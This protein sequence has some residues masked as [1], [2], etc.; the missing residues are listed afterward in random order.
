MQN[1]GIDYSLGQSNTDSETGIRYGVINQNAVG[2]AWSDESEPF[3]GDPHCPS[4]GNEIPDLADWEDEVSTCQLCFADVNMD[5]VT[6]EALS[7]FFEDA[8]YSAECGESGDIFILNSPYFTYAQF[9]SPCAPGAVHL[10]DPL[11]E[12]AEG[13]KG[14]CFGHDWFEGEVAPYPVYAVKSGEIV[15]P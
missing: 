4:C 1:L 14:Y 9:C 6:G 7:H 13:N 2:R 10:E 11:D 12:P 15:K 3:Y 5:E 8:E